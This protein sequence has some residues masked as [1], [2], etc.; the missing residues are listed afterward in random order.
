MIEQLWR[1]V[2][3]VEPSLWETHWYL[4]LDGS[5][6]LLEKNRLTNMSNDV[7]KICI[8]TLKGICIHGF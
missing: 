8:P 1:E 2:P 7:G 6:Y 3:V 5:E 4:R